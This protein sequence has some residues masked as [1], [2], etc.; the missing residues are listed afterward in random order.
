MT[1]QILIAISVLCAATNQGYSTA[2]Y[3]A[4]SCI[5]NVMKCINKTHNKNGNIIPEKCVRESFK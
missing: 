2:G 1:S 3:A 4:S 5:S